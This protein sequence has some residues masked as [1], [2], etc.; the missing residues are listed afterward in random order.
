MT[1]ES[2]FR[3]MRAVEKYVNALTKVGSVIH[4][5]WGRWMHGVGALGLAGGAF[6]RISSLVSEYS[7][8]QKGHYGLRYSTTRGST[9]LFSIQ[10]FVTII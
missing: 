2:S 10:V 7:H 9:I 8:P 1:N 4:A 6:A 3:Q 5:P